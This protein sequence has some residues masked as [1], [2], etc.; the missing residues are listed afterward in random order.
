MTVESKTDFEFRYPMPNN[1]TPLIIKPRHLAVLAH[2]LGLKWEEFDPGNGKYRASGN[3][4]FLTSFDTSSHTLPCVEY[5]V[6]PFGFPN[7]SGL[8]N[9]NLTLPTSAAIQFLFG[10]IPPFPPLSLPGYEIGSIWAVYETADK[11]DPKGDTSEKIKGTRHFMP[12]HMLGFSDI[13]SLT[14]PWFRIHGCAISRLASPAEYSGGLTRN[15]EG[16]RVFRLNLEKCLKQSNE[17]NTKKYIW[18]K[19][20]LERYNELLSDFPA[21]WECE[22]LSDSVNSEEHLHFLDRCQ[23]TWEACTAYLKPNQTDTVQFGA[24]PGFTYLDLVSAQIKHSVSYWGDAWA[25]VKK[26]KDKPTDWITKGA[27]LYWEY[28]PKVIATLKVKNKNIDEHNVREAWAVMMLRA[29]CWWRCHFVDQVGEGRR[30]QRLLTQ[31]TLVA[32][33]MLLFFKCSWNSYCI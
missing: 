26:A 3:S 19:W 22:Q 6:S 31:D 2:L 4:Q 27:H 29:F 11:L 21:E 14:A 9:P 15:Q 18:R 17:E 16:F 32:K 33:P 12:V 5:T 23:D 8:N 24:S 7:F 13:I 25:K 20:V 28:L 1:L 30:R 10:Y